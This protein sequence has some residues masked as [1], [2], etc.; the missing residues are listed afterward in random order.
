MPI[1]YNPQADKDSWND[2]K[3]FFGKIF[4]K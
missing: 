1:E 4:K 2:M 3:M